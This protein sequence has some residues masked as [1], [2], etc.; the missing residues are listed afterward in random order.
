MNVRRYRGKLLVKPSKAAM[1]R[2]R[3]RLAAELR[4]LRGAN[5]QAVVS[6]L[7]P[8]IRG[9]SAYYRTVVS[10]RAFCALDNY[11][12]QLTYKWAKHSHPNKPTRWVVQRYFGEFY[13]S[14]RD[15]WVFGDRDSGVYLQKH[16][17]T[18]IVRHQMVPGRASP[19]DPALADYWARR[20][21]R[22]QAPLGG[23]S[24]RLLKAQGG[25]CPTCGGL[26]LYAG[27]EPQSPDEWE[28]WLAATRKAVRK[29][30]LAA[31][32]GPGKQDEPAAIRLV[33]AWCQRRNK[34]R[35]PGRAPCSAY[36]P[37]GLA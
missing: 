5:A 9:W 22:S 34:P 36:E 33:H 37:L 21:Q 32:E 29:E 13:K 31:E 11:V 8:I 4:S 27:Q 18:K 12:W 3:S 17:W 23:V 35:E 24:Q 15:K 26:L 7:N 20:R 6:R 25:R 30:A 2:Y 14:R 28:Q 16:A 10:S 19:D 1:R